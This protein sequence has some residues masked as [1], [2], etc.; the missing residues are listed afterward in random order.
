M[1]I[2]SHR[3][4]LQWRLLSHSFIFFLKITVICNILPDDFPTATEGVDKEIDTAIES[5][6]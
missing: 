1:K 3:E 5:D 4:R 2:S 6:Q